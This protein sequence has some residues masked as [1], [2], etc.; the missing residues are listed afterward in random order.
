MTQNNSKLISWQTTKTLILRN[1]DNDGGR[2][3]LVG[4]VVY[5]FDFLVFSIFVLINN[6]LYAAGNVISRV[7]GALLGF[8]LHR[9]WTF[10]TKYRHS[11]DRQL[12]MY[13]FL[14]SVNILVST[15]LLYIL[16]DLMLLNEFHARIIIDSIIIIFTFA[17]SKL[18][19]FIGS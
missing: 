11:K 4:G 10:K 1:L 17:V 12:L 16:V 13:I 8:F 2:Y 3:V 14:L 19:I 9:S 18:F 6:E 7:L 15:L 5:V